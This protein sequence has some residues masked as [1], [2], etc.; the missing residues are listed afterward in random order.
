MAKRTTAGICVIDNG[1]WLWGGSEGSPVFNN[2]YKYDIGA[3]LL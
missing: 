3:Q 1:V 2:T